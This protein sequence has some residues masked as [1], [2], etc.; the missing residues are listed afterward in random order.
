MAAILNIILFTGI[1]LNVVA[2]QLYC[3]N[4]C[5][6]KC[7][8]DDETCSTNNTCVRHGRKEFCS[9]GLSYC[10]KP[11]VCCGYMT[12][13]PSDSRCCEGAITCCP[14]D[15]ICCGIGTCCPADSTCC[16]FSTCCAKGSTCDGIYCKR[17]SSGYTSYGFS[18]YY[19]V[20]VLLPL[21]AFLALCNYR[22]RRQALLRASNECRTRG[23]VIAPA[24]YEGLVRIGTEPVSATNAGYDQPP[25]AYDTVADRNTETVGEPLD[26]PTTAPP[27]YY[28]LYE[29]GEVKAEEETTRNDSEQLIRS[30]AQESSADTTRI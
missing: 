16:G 14:V 28:D 12:C 30:D 10:W 25:P 7:C 5:G 27:S 4:R 20:A 18:W 15:A 6:T 2:A 26:I 24:G 13:C 9:D 17:S 8:D 21:S 1:A 29:D 22:R 3:R 11:N 19:L 23:Q